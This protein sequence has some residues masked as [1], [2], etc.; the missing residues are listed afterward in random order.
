MSDGDFI[1]LLQRVVGGETLSAEQSASAFGAI[2]AGAVPEPAIASLLTALAI[3]RPSVDEIVGAARAMRASMTSIDAPSGAIDLC[4]TG[5]DGLATLNISTACVFVVAAAGVPV[6]KHGNRNMSSKSGAADALEALGA[7]IEVGGSI[8]ST[9][10]RE[11]DVCF[12]FAQS[13]HPALK[14]AAPIRRALGFRTM[15]NLLGPLCSPARVKRQLVGVYGRE[16]IEPMALALRELGAEHAWV[17]CGGD[18]LD[19]VTTTDVTHVAVLENG[20]VSLRTV[21]PED[22]G[23]PRATLRDL[24]GGTAQENANAI[25]ELMAGKT[26]PYRD[27]V[28]LNSAAALIVA[29]KARDLKEGA[30]IAAR[31]I[32]SGAARKT[33]E[34]FIAASQKAAA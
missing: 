29:G 28:L 24:R 9:C 3:R 12:L 22:A 6:A 11:T 10:L 16:W 1:Q 18:G 27:I 2:M 20:K 21:T 33:L 7:Q 32:D 25:R 15:F 4:G 31:A 23:M 26:G 5:G 14:L 19:E 17:V 13:Y 8:A 34:R 30:G